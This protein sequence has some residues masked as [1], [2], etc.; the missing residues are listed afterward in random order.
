MSNQINRFYSP[1][2]FNNNQDKQSKY[3]NNPK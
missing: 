1:L 3:N 2:K